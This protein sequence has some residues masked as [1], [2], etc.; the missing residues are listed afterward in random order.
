MFSE[1]KVTDF[2]V[3]SRLRGDTKCVLGL[4]LLKKMTVEHE[5]YVIVFKFWGEFKRVSKGGLKHP[6]RLTLLKSN[7][8][9]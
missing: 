3:K 6:L 2:A 7:R 4:G 8:I 5:E 9:Y 1:I